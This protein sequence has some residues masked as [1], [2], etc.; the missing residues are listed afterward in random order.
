MKN[1]FLR[2]SLLAV[3]GAAFLVSGCQK[4]YTPTPIEFHVRT[5]PELKPYDYQTQTGQSLYLALRNVYYWYEGGSELSL[6]DEVYEGIPLKYELSLEDLS[7]TPGGFSV[8]I[9]ITNYGDTVHTETHVVTDTAGVW[10]DPAR[11]ASGTFRIR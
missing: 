1:P 6:Y 11:R 4:E 8:R 3:T 10:N 9:D 5:V 2:I 7:R